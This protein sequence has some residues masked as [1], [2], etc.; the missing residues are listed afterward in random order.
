VNH[1]GPRI[2]VGQGWGQEMNGWGPEQAYSNQVMVGLALVASSRF[3]LLQQ[4][5]HGGD[6]GQLG[7]VLIKSQ[8]VRRSRLMS[9]LPPKA[10]K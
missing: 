8:I 3:L 1:L 5:R 10:D 4:P 2:G 9:A 6:Y 7:R